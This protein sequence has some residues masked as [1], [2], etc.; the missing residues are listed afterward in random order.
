MTDAESEPPEFDPEEPFALQLEWLANRY[1]P[2]YFLG[3]R[4]RP[5]L[6]VSSLGWHA[7]RNAAVVAFFFGLVSLATSFAETVFI[8][9]PGDPWSLAFGLLSVAAGVRIWSAAGQLGPR[10]E[11]GDPGEGRQLLRAVGLAALAVVMLAI[12]TAVALF[13]IGT[14]MA[15]ANGNAVVGAAICAG[16][17]MI[18]VLGLR[19]RPT[20]G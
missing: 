8:R 10:P 7:K 16:V 19:R 6:H 3:G 11:Y 5:E 18:A 20:R 9:L 15:V 14:A 17:A 4:I 1:N 12:A 13:G 2:G